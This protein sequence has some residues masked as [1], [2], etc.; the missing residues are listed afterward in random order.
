MSRCVFC[1]YSAWGGVHEDSCIYKFMPFTKFGEISPTISSNIFSVPFSFSFPSWTRITHMWDL[2][3]PQ[4]VLFS[5]FW[6]KK[7]LFVY[8]WLL[9]MFSILDSF[10]W[11]SFKNPDSSFCHLQSICKQTLLVFVYFWLL[12]SAFKQF[13]F[14]SS[15]RVHSCL[16]F[17]MSLSAI[18]GSRPW[19]SYSW[20][21][22]SSSRR[23]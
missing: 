23:W 15:S 3:I 1:T 6:K 4:E 20:A 17:S 10:H 19:E 7:F 12:S 16:W 8:F 22:V 2:L 11:S 9:M 5:F 21:P 14:E 13:C 18:T